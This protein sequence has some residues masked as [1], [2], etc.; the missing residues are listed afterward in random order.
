MILLDKNL[1]ALNEF[2][3]KVPY[4]RVKEVRFINSTKIMMMDDTIF[5]M[6][7]LFIP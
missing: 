3:N 6:K 5:D 2:I 4:F 1:Q 7:S